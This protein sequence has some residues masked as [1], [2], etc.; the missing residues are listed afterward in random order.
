MGM[1]EH[2]AVDQFVGIDVAKATL[3]MGV[4]PSRETLQVAY[5]ETGIERLVERLRSIAPKGVVL[6]ATGGL[7]TRLSAEWMA[8]GWTVAVVNPR[9]PA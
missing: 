5:D 6:E 8:Q 3:E 9:S 4:Y 2:I 7:E 1:N